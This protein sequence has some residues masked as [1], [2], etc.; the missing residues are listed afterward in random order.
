MMNE[1]Q[2]RKISKFLSLIL[3]HNPGKIGLNLDPQGWADVDELLQKVNGFR[4][5]ELTRAD[6]DIV[7]ETNN[8]KRFAY[9]PDGKQ[10]RASQGHS[11]KIDLG[12]E[13]ATPPAVLYHGT[14]TR[15][16]D[17]IMAQGLQS[18]SRQHV[19]LSWD[20]ET[21]TTVGKRHG[22]VVILRIDAAQMAADNLLFYLSENDVWLTDHVPVKYISLNDEGK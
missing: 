6:L 3:R 14:A 9:S 4:K 8:K 5:W 22:K 12:L 17:S 16:L 21:A 13:P 10:I 19:H 7:V 11:I 2:T 20:T 18:K 15:F 1:Q